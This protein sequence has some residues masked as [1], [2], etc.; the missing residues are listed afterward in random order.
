MPGGGNEN[1][2]YH[3]V[4]TR[5]DTSTGSQYLYNNKGELQYTYLIFENG[6]VP[7]VFP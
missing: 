2:V 6:G 4:D 7:T 3:Y 5:F 1:V